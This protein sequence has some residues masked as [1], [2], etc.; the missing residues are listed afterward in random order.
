MTGLA[1]VIA[2]LPEDFVRDPNEAA[3]SCIQKNDICPG[4]AI[5]NFDR[6]VDPAIQH[7][8]LVVV[9]VAAG[10][11]I[12]FGLAILAH[13]RRWLATPVLGVTGA[14]YTIPSIAAFFLVLPITGF[15]NKTAIIALTAYTL[16]TIYRNVLAGLN[17][18]PA[19]T[20]DAARGM[21][22]TDMQLLW[23]VE[24]PL[25]LPEIFAGLRIATVT[26]VALASLAV[27][28]GGG[29]LG[30]EIL[31]GSKFTFKTGILTAGTLLIL[32]AFVL[33]AALVLLQRYL[34]PWRR[35]TAQ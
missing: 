19:E 1:P 29:G 15:G 27:L 35:A 26:T 6:Y 11:A 31:I 4:W 32:L 16:Q 22:L 23:R 14:L 7:L 18:V 8:E 21:G 30:N 9:S 5:D 20:K 33:D 3:D 24:I 17:N 13:R 10:F 28:I 25:A 34:T 12:A 2:Q